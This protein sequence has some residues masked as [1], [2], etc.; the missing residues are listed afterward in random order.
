MLL[1]GKVS[2]GYLKTKLRLTCRVHPL[3]RVGAVEEAPWN[4]YA[5]WRS[6]NMLEDKCKSR[7]SHRPNSP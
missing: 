1:W 7:S 2:C 4:N 6:S 5:Q 3:F